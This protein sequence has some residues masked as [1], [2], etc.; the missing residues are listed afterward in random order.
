MVRDHRADINAFEKEQDN[1]RIH[2]LTSWATI[3]LPTLRDHLRL[4]EAA[5]RV[6]GISTTSSLRK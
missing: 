6:V 4:A 3:T 1:G 2:D 5:Q